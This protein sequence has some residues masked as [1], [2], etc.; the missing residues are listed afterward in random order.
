MS[1]KIDNS[2][3]RLENIDEFKN[4]ILELENVLGHFE[5][6]WIFRKYFLSF[7]YDNLEENSDYLKAY[8]I[9]IIQSWDIPIVFWLVLKMRIFGKQE[10]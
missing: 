3:T 1:K 5:L 6:K 9:S 4:S 7:C 2:E 8:D 10:R